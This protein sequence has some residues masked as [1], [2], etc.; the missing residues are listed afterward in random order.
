M[1]AYSAGNHGQGVALSGRIFKIK[2]RIIVPKDAPKLK[3]DAMAGYGAELVY[4]DRYK[5]NIDDVIKA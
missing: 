2:T 1:L 3:L 4:F 5:E